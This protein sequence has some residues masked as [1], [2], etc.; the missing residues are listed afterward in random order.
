M[1]SCSQNST[2]PNLGTVK[3]GNWG[4]QLLLSTATDVECVLNASAISGLPFSYAWR[5][6]S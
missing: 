4:Q 2:E 3:L 1:I 6:G 5:Y